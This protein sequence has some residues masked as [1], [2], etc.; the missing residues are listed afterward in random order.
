MKKYF[1]KEFNILIIANVDSL[2]IGRHTIPKS[3]TS[4]GSQVFNFSWFPS[5]Q[6][7][8][9]PKVV[10]VE[11]IGLRKEII[12]NFPCLKCGPL[13]TKRFITLLRN[14]SDFIYLIEASHFKVSNLH[15][16]EF[17]LEIADFGMIVTLLFRSRQ[18]CPV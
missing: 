1:N 11:K 14:L 12:R 13:F 17:L 6:L 3:S 8:L 15:L 16:V 2:E 5:L 9:V 10:C 18:S 4:V 7:Q